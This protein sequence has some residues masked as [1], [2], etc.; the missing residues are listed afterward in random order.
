MIIS[1]R[2]LIKWVDRE[3]GAVGIRHKRKRGVGERRR[4]RWK[5]KMSFEEWKKRVLALF[6][7]FVSSFPNRQVM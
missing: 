3:E 2:L 6:L 1:G 7:N 4:K 5:L